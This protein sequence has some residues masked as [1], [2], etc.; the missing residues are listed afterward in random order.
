MK[1]S[2][3][4]EYGLRCLI[5]IAQLGE[6]GVMTI[7]E[8]SRREG[9]TEPHAAK[10]LAILRKDGYI[11]STRG[12]AG[13]YRL[14][15]TPDRIVVGDVLESLGGRLVE[16]EFCARHSGILDACAHAEDCSVMGLWNRIQAAVDKV[17]FSLSLADL[18]DGNFQEGLVQLQSMQRRERSTGALPDPANVH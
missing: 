2:A 5:A 12:Q 8:I 4:E 9:L 16:T 17:V 14:A 7:P 10:L 11:T 18:M 13:G 1:F 3:Q 6:S 15:M